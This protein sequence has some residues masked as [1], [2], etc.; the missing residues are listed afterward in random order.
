VKAAVATGKGATRALAQARLVRADAYE[1]LARADRLEA[2]AM[3]EEHSNEVE[4]AR[5]ALDRNGLG[6]VLGVSLATVDRLR[7]A[8]CPVLWVCES[9]RFEVA[10]VLQWLRERS[11]EVS[12]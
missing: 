3:E 5:V 7:L 10:A 4:P 12:R 8:G 11:R 1:A 6:L 9:P 2:A